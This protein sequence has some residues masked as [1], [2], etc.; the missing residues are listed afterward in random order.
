MMASRRRE[1]PPMAISTLPSFPSLALEYSPASCC[2]RPESGCPLREKRRFDFYH[3]ANLMVCRIISSARDRVSECIRRGRGSIDYMLSAGEEVLSCIEDVERDYNID[4]NRVSLS[5]SSMGG[6]GTWVIGTQHADV[7]SGLA[8][9]AG[10]ADSRAWEKAWGWTSP[11]IGS[12]GEVK[13]AVAYSADPV[14]RIENLL[15]LPVFNVQGSDDRVV[16][17]AHS[18]NVMHRLWEL[19]KGYS[20]D[21][22][23]PQGAGHGGFEDRLLQEQQQWLIQQKRNPR[24][25]RVALKTLKI[26]HGKSHWLQFVKLEKP[27]QYGNALAEAKEDG[28]FEITADG[29]S[30]LA[31][32]VSASPAEKSER[33][34]VKVN[35]EPV[36]EGASP[37]GGE[38]VLNRE[39]EGKW[40]QGEVPQG[41][42]K[43]A[44]LEGPIE[45]A[46]L[47]PFLLVYGTKKGAA[48]EN[49]VASAEAQRFA[50]DW[51]RMYVNPCRMKADADVTD[52]DIKQYN[53]I[54]FG[55]PASNAVTAKV[56]PRLPVR[57]E[58]DSV[59]VGEKAY[60]GAGVGVKVCFPNP[61]NPE[62]YA[63]LFA[64]PTWQSLHQIINRF[65]NWF[66]WGP[67]DN[68]NWYDYAVFD[69][70][71]SSPE[72]YLCF[73][74]FDTDWKLDP[75]LQWSG[76][77]S[78]RTTATA[79]VLPRYASLD[80]IPAEAA[81]KDP[82]S[83]KQLYLSD[84][85]PSQIDQHKGAINSDRSFLGRALSIGKESRDRGLG[86][87]AP[88]AI[89]FDLAGKFERFES[90][91]GIDL[92]GAE[93]L[94]RVRKLNEWVQYE[95]FGDGR[96]L[97]R[98]NWLQGDS[99]PERIDVSIRCV[100]KLRL[101]VNGSRARWHLGSTAWANAAVTEPAA[102]GDKP[103]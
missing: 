41:L 52:E 9:L 55:A 93:E 7:F 97:Y 100:K 102:P 71:T 77:E 42:V 6:T 92:E 22:R 19:P 24:P 21:Y 58:G 18:R 56:N 89:E 44:R 12:L 28:S 74:F 2:H 76:V 23:E 72:T 84:L 60:R 53:L 99:P 83:L 3:R 34:S 78:D 27:L 39:R 90:E 81:S 94:S 1:P 101:Q 96:C 40:Q 68:H 13:A 85:L 86:L 43:K 4:R 48:D 70:K 15:N 65:G 26:R 25:N 16:P 95:V 51:Q 69:D 38:L 87:K 8:P 91:V 37:A 59:L 50:Q 82:S 64:G 35:G 17:V 80:S 14:H 67:L 66:H 5:G 62:R 49:R 63:V 31:L 47:S 30:S 46:F 32:N 73:G 36:W 61:L 75:K 29:V 33:L 98:T 10:N 103:E 20:V 11:G 57:V 45:D 54:L 88:S 79:R